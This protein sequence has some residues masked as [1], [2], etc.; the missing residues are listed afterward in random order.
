MAAKP[1][2]LAVEV[3][4][5]FTL[6]H[7]DIM[8]NADTRRGKPSVHKKWNDNYG[9]PF[10]GDAMLIYAYRLLA[11][12]DEKSLPRFVDGFLLTARLSACEG[13]QYDM[14]FREENRCVGGRIFAHD[15]I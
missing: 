10:E 5:N 3:F 4:H 8:D 13:Q 14:G 6:L 9:Y 1:A 2:A 12:C 11:G 7:D 15:R